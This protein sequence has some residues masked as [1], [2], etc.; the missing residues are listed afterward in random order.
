MHELR[1]S[2]MHGAAG[3]GETYNMQVRHC[4]GPIS[5]S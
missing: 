4:V 1:I 5:S 2:R 3:F